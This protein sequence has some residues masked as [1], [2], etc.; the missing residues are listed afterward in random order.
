MLMLKFTFPVL[1]RQAFEN[2]R[3]FNRSFSRAGGRAGAGKQNALGS[4]ETSTVIFRSLYRNKA[5]K[6]E[7]ECYNR[8]IVS[9]S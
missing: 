3:V 7:T 5:R 9:L 6:K 2:C 8:T 4:N 1:L